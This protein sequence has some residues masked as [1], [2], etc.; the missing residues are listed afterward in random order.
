MRVGGGFQAR[1]GA[2]PFALARLF[3]A[4][5]NTDATAGRFLF[6]KGVDGSR[7]DNIVLPQFIV[8]D[9]MANGHHLA[10]GLCSG[11]TKVAVPPG[12]CT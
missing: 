10:Y 11:T 12:M 1:S 4:N 9:Q 8:N 2:A 7:L 6:S 3:S 5:L